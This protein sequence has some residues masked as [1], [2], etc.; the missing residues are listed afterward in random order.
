MHKSQA[1]YMILHADLRVRSIDLAVDFYRKVG[2]Q[3]VDQQ[4]L[5]GEIVRKVSRGKY[6]SMKLALLRVSAVGAMIELL[7]FLNGSPD[8]AVE[9]GMVSISKGRRGKV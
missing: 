7:E 2:F 5:E 3:L 8:D 1:V 9:P 6:V 4:V